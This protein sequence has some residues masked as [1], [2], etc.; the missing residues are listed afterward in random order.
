MDNPILPVEPHEDNR[1]HLPENNVVAAE[2]P[3]SGNTSKSGFWLVAALAGGC[4]TL[5]I[6]LIS[7]CIFASGISQRNRHIES[8][9]QSLNDDEYALK[10]H[11]CFNK[12]K[13][14]VNASYLSAITPFEDFSG[15]VVSALDKYGT[16][17]HFHFF[18]PVLRLQRRCSIDNLEYDM[19]I[20]VLRASRAEIVVY[21]APT[22]IFI[23]P[24][25][26]A[27]SHISL[28]SG[29]Q[30][31]GV[32]STK[33][34]G[35]YLVV[36]A[37]GAGYASLVNSTRQVVWT[38]KVERKEIIVYISNAEVL[39]LQDGRYAFAYMIAGPLPFLN[40]SAESY[41]CVSVFEARKDANVTKLCNKNYVQTFGLV[42]TKAGSLLM[43]AG[44]WAYTSGNIDLVEI[45]QNLTTM[46]VKQRILS[47]IEGFARDFGA[48]YKVSPTKFAFAASIINPDSVA[49][50][51]I[52]DYATN[53]FTRT[54][55]LNMT[56]TYGT[57][58][59]KSE[60]T[61]LPGNGGTIFTVSTHSG[62]AAIPVNGGQGF[63]REGLDTGFGLMAGSGD[64][65]YVVHAEDNNIDGSEVRRIWKFYPWETETEVDCKG[66]TYG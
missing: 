42:E 1:P 25:T 61:R 2:A 21:I 17:A 36:Y 18:S 48:A 45:Y 19:P 53:K 7:V 20:R 22:L 3:A 66:I 8:L 49:L 43:L 24:Q 37:N 39:R 60:I 34:R 12:Y 10:Y 59:M 50:I 40:S 52:Y 31:A 58:T 32:L 5:L 56:G 29:A 30:V 15:Y 55:T 51:L 57:A 6:L 65:G 64:G 14:T 33:V 23:N 62:F 47:N 63:V 38:K 26:C 46:S 44:H 27:H 13:A 4:A 16:T 9:S 35:E 54:V 28:G 11:A 41:M